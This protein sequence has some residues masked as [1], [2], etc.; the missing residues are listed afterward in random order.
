MTIRTT[1]I[2]REDT[3]TTHLSGPYVSL[4]TS[5]EHVLLSA[6]AFFK[7]AYRNKKQEYYKHEFILTKKHKTNK[8]IA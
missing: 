6:W 2:D 8:E 1:H 5:K 7:F 4:W 3:E